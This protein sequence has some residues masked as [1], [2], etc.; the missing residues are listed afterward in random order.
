MQDLRKKNG[1]KRMASTRYQKML[2]TAIVIVLI[3]YNV[4]VFLLPFPRHYGFWV[5]YSF[6]LISMLFTAAVSLYV[7]GR[8]GLRSKFYGV[9]LVYVA[10]SYLVVQ[11]LLG[12][13]QMA[14]PVPYQY[15]LIINIVLLGACLI[16]LI[17]INMAKE[18]IER[19]DQ[20]VS[21]KVFY[22]RSL[23]AELEGLVDGTKD[24][25]LRKMIKELAETIR[26]S[27]PM[28]SPQLAALENK[29]E[30]KAAQ[31]AESIHNVEAAAALCQEIQ[32]LFAER[33]RK[34]KILKS[35]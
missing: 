2:L 33:N 31:L 19:I 6:S 3:V 18:E 25:T 15:N 5:G 4:V 17:G 13:R 7:I 34:C 26:Y 1:V 23:R 28:S 29:I 24:E 32:M 11:V 27:D 30:V 9:P 16:G 12:L 20:K 22:L 14:L 21:E 10:W 8:E 35:S